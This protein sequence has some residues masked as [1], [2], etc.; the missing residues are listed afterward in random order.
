MLDHFLS[1]WPIVHDIIRLIKADKSYSK[2]HVIFE[3]A[4]EIPQLSFSQFL[5][6]RQPVTKQGNF[7]K[8]VWNFPLSLFT[9]LQTQNIAWHKFCSLSLNI[10]KRGK[11]GEKQNIAQKVTFPITFVT[12]CSYISMNIWWFLLTRFSK[13]FFDKRFG[14]GF[15]L[16]CAA[17]FFN[18]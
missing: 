13:T 14:L 16:K 4:F 5:S 15:A 9:I 1:L 3:T 2:Q 18:H 10:V 17:S 12:D 7:K 11:S 6:F 8:S